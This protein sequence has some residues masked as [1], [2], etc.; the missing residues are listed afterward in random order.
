MTDA[1]HIR[2]THSRWS[3]TQWKAPALIGFQ[4][5]AFSDYPHGAETDILKCYAGDKVLRSDKTIVFEGSKLFDLVTKLSVW[6][7]LLTATHKVKHYG[8]VVWMLIMSRD[9]KTETEMY[10]ARLFR[11][12]SW[13]SWS[14][15]DFQQNN[16]SANEVAQKQKTWTC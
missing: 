7:K 1:V 11:S 5:W 14:K 4:Y 3:H 9:E 16:E 2:S 6:S 15:R 12:S 10:G 8:G 13:K